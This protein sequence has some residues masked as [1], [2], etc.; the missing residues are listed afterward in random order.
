MAY[1]Y[2]YPRPAVTVDALLFFENGQ[3]FELL[4]IKRKHEPF[5]NAWAIPGGFVDQNET[6]DMAVQRELLE[7]TGVSGIDLL[8]FKAYGNPG[9]DPRGHT[10]SIVFYAFAYEKPKAIA[11]DDASDTAWFSVDDLPPMAF[12]HQ[13]IIQEARNLILAP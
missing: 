11:A 4:L 3:N 13:H 10:V 8:Q 7:E 1:T 6:L 9:R 5:K 2:D 12:D